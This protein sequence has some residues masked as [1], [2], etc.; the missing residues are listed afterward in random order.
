MTVAIINNYQPHIGIGKYCFNLFEKLRMMKK[1]VDMVY[2]ES[3][4]NPYPESG[5]VKV[6]QSFNLP[7]LNK[8][9]SWYYYFPSR[10]PQGYDLY[11]ISSQYL[12][13]I[14]KFRKPCVVTHMDIAPLRFK[15]PLHLKFFVKRAMKYYKNADKII[16]ISEKSKMELAGLNIVPEEMIHAINLG[17]DERVYRPLSRESCREKLGLPMDKK[18]IL[19]VGSEEGRKNVPT[20]LKALHLLKKDVPD[21]M[22]I[23][24]G[25]T[26]PANEPLK[27]G[28]DVR[29]YRGI[30][31]SEMP[32]FYGAAD[33]FVFPATYEG[34]IAYPP[35]EAMACG[36]PTVITDELDVFKDGAVIMKP[37]DQAALARTMLKI[38]SEPG[39]HRKLSAAAL[40]TAGQFT[41]TRE[42]KETCRVYEDVLEMS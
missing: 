8:T 34:G 2:L 23:R 33:V 11:H 30:P 39:V 40:K 37:Y 36:L 5:V 21:F 28:L 26:D 38:L 35:L 12:A 17:Y 3:K 22:F 27:A 29:H 1:D 10:L 7:I 15:Y 41:L 24:I 19:N 25:G 18:I 42:V 6:K 13:R 4:D 14:A 32:L 31:E 9:F 16:A 20:L